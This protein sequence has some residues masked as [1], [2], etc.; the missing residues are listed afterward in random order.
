MKRL[1]LLFT[2]LIGVC[3][4]LAYDFKAGD[5][6]YNINNDGKSV[7][8]V[9]RFYPEFKR[10]Y[11][12]Q[13]VLKLPSEVTY[14][15]NTYTVTQIQAQA[16]MDC[17]GLTG[18]EL[19]STLTKIDALSFM[20][21]T[22]LTSVTVPESVTSL[23][24]FEGCVNLESINIPEAVIHIGSYAFSGCSKLT[25]MDIPDGVTTIDYYAFKNCTGLRSLKLP[26]ALTYLGKEALAGC[27]GLRALKLPRALKE[28]GEGAFRGCTGL[29]TLLVP[30]SVDTIWDSAFSDCSRLK[31]VVIRGP[32]TSIPNCTFKGCSALEIIDF[33]NTVTWIG[34]QAFSG[35]HSLKGFTI[36]SSVTTIDSYAFEG[37]TGFTTLVIPNSVTRLGSAL[38]MGCDNLTDLTLP[39]TADVFSGEWGWPLM[40]WTG[41]KELTIPECVTE[42]GQWALSDCT[43][44][45][46]LVIPANV[47]SI[48]YNAFSGCT[49]LKT[50]IV[51]DT[52]DYL[53]RE[54]PGSPNPEHPITYSDFFISSPIEYLYM[55]RPGLG[56]LGLNE[57]LQTAVIG[58]NVTE[59]YSGSF[60]ECY[61]MTEVV[62]PWTLE[63][64]KKGGFLRCTDLETI[65]LHAPV[66]PELEKYSFSSETYAK[67]ALHVP[68]GTRQVYSEAPYWC[69]FINVLDDLEV[70]GIEEVEDDNVP[71]EITV[72]NLQGRELLRTA[73][74]APFRDL[75]AGIYIKKQGNK[76]EKIVIP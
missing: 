24:G 33:P 13:G 12:F 38:F 69:N 18:V 25:S 53:V 26:T 76:T 19:P 74:D 60:D 43:G 1:L 29:T 61:K 63:K 71:A 23:G 49:G 30:E 15:S 62:L 59:I 55:G 21:C 32:I 75:P 73:G 8:I 35:C 57:A 72:Y 46:K 31:M 10:C 39:Q 36:P 41:L 65:K 4:G 27:T 34:V 67:A 37:C 22:G 5:L 14:N 45:E 68:K 58:D 28:I 56:Y 40:G 2:V 51:E 50:L 44:L 20:G 17:V 70:T 11:Y 7:T 48:W 42:I 54:D 66:P 6:Y 64:I 9:N 47:K 52:P 16:F 3:R